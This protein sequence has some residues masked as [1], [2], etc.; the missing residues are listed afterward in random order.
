MT[1]QLNAFQTKTWQDVHDDVL[2]VIRQGMIKLGISSNP[3]LGVGS[4]EELWATTIANETQ[5][6]Y[7][8]QRVIGDA[9]MPDTANLNSPP[10]PVG[11]DLTRL[12]AIKGLSPRGPVGSLG[13]LVLACSAT[14]T[15]TG[16]TGGVVGTGTQLTDSAGLRYE[17]TTSGTYASGALVPIASIDSG[18]QT[19]HVAGDTLVWQSAPA[20]CNPKQIVATGGLTGGA[21][22]ETNEA[23]RARLLN[24]ERNPPGSGNWAQVS[25]FATASSPLVQLAFVYPAV[26]GP[27]T[28][29]VAVTAVT[30]NRIIDP[31][32][33]ANIVAPYVA[34]QLPEYVEVV[35][36]AVTEQDVDVAIGL[37][38][39]SAPTASPAGPGG[40]WVDGSPWPAISG[41]GNS[42]ANVTAVTS[43]TQYTVNAPTAPTDG[44][45]HICMWDFSVANADG[46]FGQLLRAKVLSHSG[47]AGAY[48]I[49]TDTPFPNVTASGGTGTLIFPDAVN[50]QTY[51]STLAATMMQ[52]GPGEKTSNVSV[53]TRG[54]R[55]P[56]P[57]AAQPY[58]LNATQLKAVESTGPEVLATAWYYRSATT[59][60]VPASVALAPYQFVLRNIGF[61]AN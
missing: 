27:S 61:Y 6:L 46:T 37:T 47:S 33:L 11:S 49:V 32:I 44:V 24:L 31:T 21:A 4:D 50:M 34:G 48:V 43:S 58:S 8:N 42:Y 35:V 19:N 57:Q 17:V 25:N 7:V 1:Y 15:I 52:M 55:H 39:P 51:C 3:Q 59:P 12:M 5:P 29:H 30:R 38:L 20:F 13:F 41:T 9:Q 10:T 40:G 28:V 36:T 45:S 56:T 54:Y 60:T 16:R 14:T 2:R 23:A 22:Q 18:P 26:N 53:L